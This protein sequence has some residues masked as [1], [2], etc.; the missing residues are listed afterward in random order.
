MLSSLIDLSRTS[1]LFF[2]IELVFG[3]PT[4][5]YLFWRLWE[6]TI[7]PSLHPDEP[8]ELPYLIPC[9]YTSTV[10]RELSKTD[11]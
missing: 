3:L 2:V 5:S 4:V 7:K 9:V 8:R 6:F 1:T 11:D 10:R